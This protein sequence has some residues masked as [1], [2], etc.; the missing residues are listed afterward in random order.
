MNS[1]ILVHPMIVVRRTTLIATIARAKPSELE[2]VMQQLHRSVA[3]HWTDPVVAPRLSIPITQF[4]IALW[5][6]VV[7]LDTVQVDFGGEKQK[8]FKLSFSRWNKSYNGVTYITWV[9]SKDRNICNFIIAVDIIINSAMKAY[10]SSS[11][12]LDGWK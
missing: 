11:Q 10:K 12:L 5:F 8:K 6:T 4:I 2:R 9:V 7:T 3:Q 1:A